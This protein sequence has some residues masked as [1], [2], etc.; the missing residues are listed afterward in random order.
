MVS[1]RTLRLFVVVARE[2]S[3]AAA[4]K[5]LGLTPAAVGLQMKALEAELGASLFDRGARRVVLNGTGRDTVVAVSDILTR[6]DALLAG[7]DGAALTGTLVMG[8]L[9]SA[10]MGAFADALWAMKKTH[11]G[12]VVRLFAGKSRD[13]AGRVADGELD[14]AIVTRPPYRLASDLAWTPLYAEPMVL[15]VPRRP[16]FT[17]PRA[18]EE[19]LRLAP[20][21]RF[22]RAAWTGYLVRRALRQAGVRARDEMELDSVEAIVELVRGGFGVSI[23]PKLANVDWAAD[24]ALRIVA[25]PRIDVVREVGLLERARHSRREATAA[26]KAYFRGRGIS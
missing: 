15:I 3:F 24:R 20:F 5:A 2:G 17:L 6:Y 7:H 9:V 26:I 22:D 16:H 10:L 14:A 1:I 21:I 19:V 18:S 23:V 4:G 12:L 11:P 13:F 25:V 8:A